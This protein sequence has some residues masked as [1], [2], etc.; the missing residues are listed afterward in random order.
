M[1]HKSPQRRDL[2]RYV[3]DLSQILGAKEY[4]MT[5]GRADGIRAVDVKN[6]SGLEYTVLADRG[7][8]IAH[9]TFKGTN[10]S[11]LSKSGIIAPQYYDEPGIG[12]IRSFFGGLLTTCG[13][14]YVGAPSNDQGEQLGIHG[15]A[16]NTPAEELHSRVE[17]SEQGPA[18]LITGKLRE[19][20]LL[21]EN[22]VL[23]REIHCAFGSTTLSVHDRVENRGFRPEPLMI[24]Y[25]ITFG[26]PLLAASSYMIAPSAKVTPRGE[27][28]AG[29]LDSWHKMQDPTPG[30]QEQFF[31][32]ELRTDSKGGTFM[33]L[34]NP[35]LELAVAVRFNRKQLDRVI[36]WKQLGEGDYVCGIEP[37]NCPIEGRAKAREAGELE[38]LEPGEIRSFDLEIEVIE[39]RKNIEELK[40][41]L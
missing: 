7:L 41:S 12:F 33:A 19:A 4:R 35:E 21:G 25:H 11:Y 22:M 32:H 14:T 30:Y 5:G 40:G 10:L 8:D 24:L 34:T 16:N 20:R 6:G 37:S 36:A 13:L 18:V 3:G 31:F 26:Y 1:S 38:F 2:L 23:S 9:L 17:W 27:A 29:H 15:R 39:G 28:E